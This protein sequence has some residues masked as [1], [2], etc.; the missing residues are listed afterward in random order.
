M[1]YLPLTKITHKAQAGAVSLVIT[2]DHYNLLTRALWILM[3]KYTH[4]LC[5]VTDNYMQYQH[6]ANGR[7]RT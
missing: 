4:L 5:T 6:M 7:Q 2:W 1:E 3:S